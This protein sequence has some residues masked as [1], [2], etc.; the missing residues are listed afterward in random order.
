MG[1]PIRLWDYDLSSI[2]GLIDNNFIN[3]IFGDEEKCFITS[4]K[5]QFSDIVK[6]AYMYKRD[7]I[8]QSIINN[9]KYNKIILEDILGKLNYSHNTDKFYN[10]NKINI[11]HTGYLLEE[12]EYT[13][14]IILLKKY[15]LNNEY[16]GKFICKKEDLKKYSIIETYTVD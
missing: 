12:V 13:T 15:S 7:I 10:K 14:P 2:E 9:N 1:F 6:F 4:K 5:N 11:S 16:F 8:D 3:S